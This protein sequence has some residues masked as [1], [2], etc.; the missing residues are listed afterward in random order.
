MP[1]AQMRRYPE[2]AR[3]GATHAERLGL[4]IEHDAKAAERLAVLA[5]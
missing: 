5:D 2:L 1:I 3:G 4:L